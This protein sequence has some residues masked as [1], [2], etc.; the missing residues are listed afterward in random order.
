M[1]TLMRSATLMHRITRMSS[2]GSLRSLRMFFASFAV[3]SFDRE[4]R[5]DEL[6]KSLL[7]LQFGR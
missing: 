6:R 1:R 2:S 5:Q 4:G 7:P 3:K